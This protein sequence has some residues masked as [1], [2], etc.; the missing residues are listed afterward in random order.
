MILLLQLDG[1]A[2]PP[3]AAPIER[4]DDRQQGAEG[5]P[6]APDVAALPETAAIAPPAP[7]ADSDI[8]VQ[9]RPHPPRSDPLQSVNTK[10]FAAT[11]AVDDAVVG[12]MALTYKHHIPDPIRSGLRNFFNNTREPVVFLNFLIQL[13]IGKA[14]E[15]VGRFAVNSTIGGAGLF[16]VAKRRPFNLPRRPNGF[17]NTLGYYGVKP[18][19]FL[20]LPLIGPTTVRDAIGGGIDRLVLPALIGRPF[21]DLAYAIASGVV[22]GL[23]RR[24][25]FDEQLR[26]L[27]AGSRDFYA[28]RRAFY[29]NQREIE[30]DRLHGRGDATT[31]AALPVPATP[32]E[33]TPPAH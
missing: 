27:R 3:P 15:T 16:D 33:P 26:G 24:A 29:L 4:A 31:P 21:S 2:L 1:G 17:A 18:G 28:A 22:G 20:F 12:P 19:A 5:M 8:L 13:H 32:A 7:A 14:A 10:T 30:I 23:D 11:Q 25:E 6:V 9:A